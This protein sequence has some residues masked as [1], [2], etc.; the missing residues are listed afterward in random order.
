MNDIETQQMSVKGR[1]KGEINIVQNK[2]KFFF[3]S[4]WVRAP[5]CPADRL[6]RLTLSDILRKFL[7]PDH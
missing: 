1:P 5:S 2:L 4:Y 6:D 3:F 7:H